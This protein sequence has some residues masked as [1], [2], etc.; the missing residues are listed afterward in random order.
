[1]PLV[2]PFSSPAF[3]LLAPSL[4]TDYTL[5]QVSLN[6]AKGQSGF[7]GPSDGEQD[8]AGSI[9]GQQQSPPPPS[10]LN[11]FNLMIGNQI[12]P[13]TYSIE[14]GQL[15]AM[16]AS[17]PNYTLVLDILA[18]PDTQNGVL[19]INLPRSLTD[20]IDQRNGADLPFIIYDDGVEIT[21]FN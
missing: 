19:T 9:Q 5:H 6:P 2:A 3:S 10:A 18:A 15:N 16:T 20:S 21:V 12:I 7:L 1:M 17:S 14:G 13:I 8:F 4:Y 11:T